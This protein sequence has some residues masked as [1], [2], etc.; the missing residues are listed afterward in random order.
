MKIERVVIKS[1][2]ALQERDDL[3]CARAGEAPL[4]A[5]CLSGINGSGKT[6][7]LEEIALLWQLFRALA[8]G[9]LSPFEW[10]ED[11][12]ESGLI[13]MRI[14]QLPGP[15]PCLWLGAGQAALW[16]SVR[17]RGPWPMIGMLFEPNR[18]LRANDS[19][20]LRYWNEHSTKLELR[21]A[22]AEPLP[23]MVFLGAEDRIVQG[24]VNDL[25]LSELEPEP[26]FRWLARYAP[27]GEKK[28]HIEHSLAALLMVDREKYV[29]VARRLHQIWPSIE[30]LDQVSP[31][32]LRPRFRLKSGQIIS[33][34][35]LS[36]GERAMLIA[37]YTVAR[38]LRPGGIV[39]IDEPELHLHLSL[40]RT[41]LVYLEQ[42]VVRELQGQLIVASHAPE[43]WRHFRQRHSRIE[44]SPVHISKTH[45]ES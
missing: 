23:N 30:L 10:M 6:T 17:D 2:K 1:R 25:D 34:D 27:S 13:A 21:G 20:I 7:Y 40:Q 22:T 45:H 32:T 29:D 35:G 8:R 18:H 37:L 31:R 33:M 38:W 42:L 24:R 26:P 4:G 9:S 15:T 12:E 36:A 14:S 11:E 19:G 44:L 43:V 41:S 16:E 3:F 5:L 39:L 28:N